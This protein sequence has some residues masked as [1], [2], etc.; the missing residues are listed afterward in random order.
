[1]FLARG[2]PG[3]GRAVRSLALTVRVL[4]SGREG[5]GWGG[6][7]LVGRSVLRVSGLAVGDFCSC[8]ERETHEALTCCVFFGEGDNV[9]PGA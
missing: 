1:V 4:I 3:T 7:K 2:Q 5:G 8:K 6:G 9:R